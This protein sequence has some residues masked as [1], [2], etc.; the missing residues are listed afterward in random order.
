LPAPDA[1]HTLPNS[2]SSDEKIND[3]KESEA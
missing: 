1:S 2:D 3:I